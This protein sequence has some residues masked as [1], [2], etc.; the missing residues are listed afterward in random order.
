MRKMPW[1]LCLWPGLPQLSRHGSWPALAVAVAAALLLNTALLATFVWTDLVG[2]QVRIMYWLALGAA[3]IVAAGVSRR[4]D[5]T[6]EAKGRLA[7][8]VFAKALDFY[9]QGNWLEAER[10]LNRLLKQNPRD[11]EA[12]LMLATLLRHTR[13]LDEATAQLNILVRLEGVG[14]W[15]L[16]IAREGQL[17]SEA[18]EEAAQAEGPNEEQALE[19]QGA[20]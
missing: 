18:R 5:G 15:E 10:T 1:A 7:E 20:L 2:S 13:R 19:Q 11:L 12:R 16:E 6:P 17:L 9:L 3:W 4:S 14:R 8:E